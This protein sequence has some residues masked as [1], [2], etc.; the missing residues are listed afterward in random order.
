MTW[1]PFSSHNNIKIVE[2]NATL[3]KKKSDGTTMAGRVDSGR[4]HPSLLPGRIKYAYNL[5][6]SINKQERPNKRNQS[7]ATL[8]LIV[9]EVDRINAIAY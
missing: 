1:C 3:I 2:M 9:I 5:H 8:V 4:T 7:L 6:R